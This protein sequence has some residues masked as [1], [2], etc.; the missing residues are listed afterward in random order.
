MSEDFI[1]TAVVLDADGLKLMSQINDW[2]RL[3][4]PETI[5]TPHPGEMAIITDKPVHEIQKNRII[6]AE[7]YA[8]LWGHII[9]LKGAYTVVAGPDGRT[10]VIPIATSALSKAGTGDVLAGIITGLRAQGLSA[11]DA[12]VTGVFI[13]ALC[14]LDAAAKIG[15]STSVIASDILDSVSRV[16]NKLNQKSS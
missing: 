1:S 4:P 14:G 6:S 16:F 5:L 12:G 9:V 13:H 10:M 7:Y 8:K 2:I 15:N 11:F 3:L